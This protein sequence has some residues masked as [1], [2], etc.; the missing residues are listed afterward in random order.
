MTLWFW[1]EWGVP[2]LILISGFA[3]FIWLILGRKDS[4]HKQALAEWR[5][6]ND[7]LEKVLA[8]HEARLQKL[9]EDKRG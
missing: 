4:P 7:A 3:F 1:A 8:S 5:R 9:E 2:L 6:H